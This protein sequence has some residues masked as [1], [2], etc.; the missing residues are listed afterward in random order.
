MKS[1]LGIITTNYAGRTSSVLTQVRPLAS[2]PYAGRYRLVDFPLSNMVNAGVRT[3]GLVMPSN[4][5]SIIDHVGSGKEWMLDRKGGGL[6]MLPGSAFGTSR[7]GSRFLL[8]D[9]VQ[10]R[11]ILERSDDDYV[12][13]SAANVVYNM[14]YRLLLE[15][16]E[17]SGADVMVLT[18]QAQG[19]NA[20]LVGFEVEGDRC[21]A[22]HHGVSYGDDAFMDCFVIRR[23]LLLQML[24][25]HEQVDYLDLFEAL[26]KDYGRIDVRVYRYKGY[27]APIF[28]VASY[29]RHNMELLS[30]ELQDELFPKDRSIMTKAHDNPPVSYRRGAHVRNSIVS[31]GC[32]L[33]GN[34]SGSILGRGVVV[35][36]GATVLNSI[37]MQSCVVKSGA[38]VENAIVDRG[39][40]IPAGT[41]L[42]G[43]TD[44][45]LIKEKAQ[46]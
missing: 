26:E 20:D 25:E 23:E 28:D 18:C 43:T 21:R 45:I 24:V 3:V 40:V 1:T 32:R 46:S 13:V 7:A 12:L 2:L 8:R 33:A 16:Y 27:A 42:R 44:E 11:I 41:E 15:A 22:L 14:D 19:D 4:Y 30:V 5:R 35:E 38:R 10:N 6:F 39:N 31:G 17:Q 9:F 34:V 37:V 36:P 29:Y